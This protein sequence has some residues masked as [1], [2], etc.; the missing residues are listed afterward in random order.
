MTEAD[1]MSTTLAP[2]IDPL[3]TAEFWELVYALDTPKEVV[4]IFGILFVIL[5]LGGNIWVIVA[6]IRQ[7]KLRHSATNMFIVSLSLSDILV[8]LVTVPQHVALWGYFS[9]LHNDALC[10]LVAYLQSC[11]LCAT[12]LSLI[13]IGADRYRAIVQPLRP[14]MTLQNAMVGCGIVWGVGLI[15]SIGV[16]FVVGLNPKLKGSGNDTYIEHTCGVL[17]E[18]VEID[19]WIRLNTIMMHHTHE[20]H[21]NRVTELI[22]HLKNNFMVESTVCRKTEK[23]LART[24]KTLLP[25]S[26]VD[27]W[28]NHFERRKRN[29]HHGFFTPQHRPYN[30]VGDIALE[31]ADLVADVFRNHL[32]EKVRLKSKFV[33]KLILTG[34]CPFN[35]TMHSPCV[36]LQVPND[37]PKD[38]KTDMRNP[39]VCSAG[40]FHIRQQLQELQDIV[41]AVKG[42]ESFDRCVR[43]HEESKRGF[44]E[45]IHSRLSTSSC[46]RLPPLSRHDRF[47]HY[48]IPGKQQ[49]AIRSQLSMRLIQTPSPAGLA[50]SAEDENDMIRI[51]FYRHRKAL[52]RKLESI[53]CLLCCIYN[54]RTR[55]L[56]Y[57]IPLTQEA[58]KSLMKKDIHLDHHGRPG[59]GR[60]VRHG[61]PSMETFH[62]SL[63]PHG[64]NLLP[65]SKGSKHSQHA[66]GT[67]A[68]G[69]AEHRIISPNIWKKFRSKAHK[70]RRGDMDTWED[71]LNV[72]EKHIHVDKN[73]AS[74]LSAMPRN[75][76]AVN[77]GTLAKHVNAYSLVVSHYRSYRRHDQH[78]EKQP[79]WLGE[80]VTVP[81]KVKKTTT[82]KGTSDDPHKI[83]AEENELNLEHTVESLRIAFNAV[84]SKMTKDVLTDIERLERCV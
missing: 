2:I 10:K 47:S 56:K 43:E 27:A 7:P 21:A 70:D 13:C 67:S 69:K 8:G 30:S 75:S 37:K 29:L 28:K 78:Y 84:Q 33:V 46:R 77:T 65:S 83:V 51:S 9:H 14:R 71:L 25:D 4:L 15:Y 54:I 73:A 68:C 16:F 64:N 49:L 42:G 12:T 36:T 50:D 41:I 1:N 35:N 53:N 26:D 79:Y 59:I 5:I 52:L 72:G 3:Q 17:Y 22:R 61:N 63:S 32:P 80:G 44:E 74:G 6:V 24:S 76:M 55:D 57:R 62:D 34:R 18:K 11:S 23:V 60:L 66:S 39:A 58:V 40:Y 81:D 31:T 38:T 19:A 45:A 82:Q 20:L 48:G